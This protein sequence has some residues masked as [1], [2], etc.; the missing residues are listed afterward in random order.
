M[1]DPIIIEGTAAAKRLSIRESGKE[2]AYM[3]A[4]GAFI[5]RGDLTDAELRAVIAQLAALHVAP[6]RL[7]TV[8]AD[9][10]E[11]HRQNEML[12]DLNNR[13][14]AERDRLRE[15]LRVI[16]KTHAD[17]EVGDDRDRCLWCH[18]PWPC[19]DF[20]YADRAFA[21]DAPKEGG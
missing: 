3:D 18:H 15:A 8:E 19:S 13:L 20:T 12:M 10:R 11:L 7:R 1:S 21:P 4:H 14:E 17:H 9:W 2:L 6:D 16:R 5:A